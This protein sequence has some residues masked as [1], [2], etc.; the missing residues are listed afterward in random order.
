M[1]KAWL[2]V[3]SLMLYA[4]GQAM[5]SEEKQPECKDDASQTSND[6]LMTHEEDQLLRPEGKEHE[7]QL[8][9]ASSRCAICK[10]PIK[11]D[12][13][14]MRFMRAMFCSP[15]LIACSHAQ[16]RAVC[17]S[18]CLDAWVTNHYA[19]ERECHLCKQGLFK[20]RCTCCYSGRSVVLAWVMI[21]LVVLA[22]GSI[23]GIYEV[24]QS[25]Q[26]SPVC[27]DVCNISSNESI[28]IICH[29]IRH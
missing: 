5:L 22:V 10:R 12:N 25:Y 24:D 20:F 1:N 7:V 18:Y 4:S 3:F 21:G 23:V 17:H 6:A 19:L 8:V 9:D 26:N 15:Q 29:L 14:C 27:P 28:D 13:G 2:V 16:C 11:K